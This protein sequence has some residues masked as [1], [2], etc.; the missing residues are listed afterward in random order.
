MCSC[1][2]CHYILYYFVYMFLFYQQ[3]SYEFRIID[4]SSDLCSSDLFDCGNPGGFIRANIA[5]GLLRDDVAPA[6][7]G[8]LAPIP[9]SSAA[10]PSGSQP[11]RSEERRVGQEDV[12]TGRSRWEQ[13]H[14]KKEKPMLRN[15]QTGE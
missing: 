3:T 2:C 14:Q 12:S 13:A 6:I 9:R 10:W 7:R 15:D 4:W 11:F 1:A 5:F 8:M